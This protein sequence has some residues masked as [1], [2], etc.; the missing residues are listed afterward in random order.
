[1]VAPWQEA[2]RAF[3]SSQRTRGGPADDADFDDEPAPVAG[4]EA[5]GAC[6]TLS[7]EAAAAAAAAKAAEEEV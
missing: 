4:A 7:T 2:W 5:D 6:A 1:V 3:R